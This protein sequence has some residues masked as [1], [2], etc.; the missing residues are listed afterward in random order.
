MV[1]LSY[2]GITMNFKHLRTFVEVAHCKSFSNAATRLHTVQSAISRHITA[3]ERDIHVTL[4]ER[5][6][7][8]VEL[9]PAGERFLQHADA[10]LKHCRLAKEDAQL[11]Q[12]GEKGLLRIGYLS[13]AC[14]H[15][16]PHLL[17]NFST[18]NSGVTVKLDEMTVSQQLQAFTE[19]AIDIGFSR[20]IEKTHEGL[21]KEKHLFDD[22]IVAVVASDHPLAT[23]TVLSLAN[24]AK[25]PLILFAR[26]H[27]P[28]LF[29]NLMT[30]FHYQQ[31]K[32]N[33]VSE[34]KSMQA[35]LTEIPSSQCVAL[36]P[37]CIQNL[38][39]KGCTFVPLQAPMHA[40]LKMLWQAKP[41][42]T[43]LTWLNWYDAYGQDIIDHYSR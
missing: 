31:L 5:N 19:S 17:R 39:T 11:I 15:F 38:H 26:A 8:M 9:T 29:D 13:S 4:F 37:A 33:V 23:K 18:L 36:V 42:A 20:P 16:L 2:F 22:P 1:Y 34:P 12:R 43:T 24:I 32:P 27:A 41:N 3:L 30:A 40:E 14:V 7:R 25:H 28:S 21:L 10:I 35:L 6:T